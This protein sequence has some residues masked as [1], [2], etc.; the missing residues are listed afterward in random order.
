LLVAAVVVQAVTTPQL[1]VVVLVVIGHPSAVNLR[2]VEEAQN[3]LY[4]WQLPRLIRSPLVR[5]ALER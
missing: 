4:R 5:V 3:L 2:A 1:V